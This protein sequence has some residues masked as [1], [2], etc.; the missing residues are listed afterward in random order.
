MALLRFVL[1]L[2][3]E[4]QCLGMLREYLNS[5]H[6]LFPLPQ[7]DAFDD[8]RFVITEIDEAVRIAFVPDSYSLGHF[9][10]PLVFLAFL[11]GLPVRLDSALAAL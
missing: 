6:F 10:F 4:S 2:D 5:F 1:F 9:Y 8:L 3:G 11:I 7:L